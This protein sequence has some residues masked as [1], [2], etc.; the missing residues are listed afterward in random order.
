MLKPGDVL[1][2]EPGAVV[3]GRGR[4]ITFAGGVIEFGGSVP[5]HII[6][7]DIELKKFGFVVTNPNLT[8]R[9]S[10]ACLFFDSSANLSQCEW[11]IDGDVIM[12]R[13]TNNP[14]FHEPV[15]YFDKDSIITINPGKSLVIG[16]LRCVFEASAPIRY[17]TRSSL[18]LLENVK[19]Y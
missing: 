3:D 19:V 13:T 7:R 16:N 18:I 10:N 8:V 6:L 1:K 2:L 12:E 17:R 5:G 4:A 9:L 15:L 11:V 14:G